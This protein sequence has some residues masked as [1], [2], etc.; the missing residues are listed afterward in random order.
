[1]EDSSSNRRWL[2]SLEEEDIN[3]LK[4]F[5]LASGSLKE[6]AEG[7]K[8]SYPTVRLRLDRLIQ[9]VHVYDD[10][11]AGDAHERHMRA[12]AA[13]GKIDTATLKTLL[14]SYRKT[15]KS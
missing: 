3:F 15:Q 2:D 10:A 12:L 9:K 1:M 6:L 4:R 11:N 5:L 13:D 8:V 7:Y 14:S